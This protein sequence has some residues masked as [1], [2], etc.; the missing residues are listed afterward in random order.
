MDKKEYLRKLRA[1]NR[2]FIKENRRYQDGEILI[3]KKKRIVV[4]RAWGV[5][6]STAE[7]QYHYREILPD[8]TLEP[9]EFH[10]YGYEWEQIQQ[11]G[12]FWDFGNDEDI[13]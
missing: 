11:T 13:F 1:L 7:V 8:N 4:I 6:S 12:E 5:S 3:M 2:E 9:Y 10:I